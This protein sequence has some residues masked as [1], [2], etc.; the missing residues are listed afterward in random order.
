MLSIAVA[1]A[2]PLVLVYTW[3]CTFVQVAQALLEKGVPVNTAD[4][5]GCTPVQYCAIFHQPVPLARLL[6][7]ECIHVGWSVTYFSYLG[8]TF[9]LVDAYVWGG[10]LCICHTLGPPSHW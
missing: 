5:Q 4:S 9:S 8:P 1:I 2:N 3:A 10:Q 7:G 6:I